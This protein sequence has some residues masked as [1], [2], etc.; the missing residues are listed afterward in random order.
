M[1][2][3]PSSR[4]LSTLVPDSRMIR[5]PVP[6]SRVIL[7]KYPMPQYDS[8][9]LLYLSNVTKHDAEVLGKL[10]D[11]ITG[12]PVTTE[13]LLA[14]KDRTIWI[15]F[16]IILADAPLDCVSSTTTCRRAVTTQISSSNLLKCHKDAR[17]LTAVLCVPCGQTKLKFI[18][19]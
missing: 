13:T 19:S 10:F 12:L 7:P 2:P 4:V 3:S 6:A 8:P 16:P 18:E 15:S 17:S 9:H 5:S 11:F 14:G 1:P